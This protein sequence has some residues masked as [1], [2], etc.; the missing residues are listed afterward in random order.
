MKIAFSTIS[1][2][3]Y[4]A[5]QMCRAALESAYDAVELYSLEGERLTVPLLEIRWRDLR[6]TFREAGV[7]ICSLN[8]WGQFSMADP[9]A[10]AAMERQVTRALELAA[11]MGCPQVK[12]FGGALPKDVPPATVFEYVAEH[13]GRIAR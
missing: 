11:E 3:A 7:P 5:E 8:S 10:R 9:Q 6:Q 12:T 4:T 13:I 1:C 2:P